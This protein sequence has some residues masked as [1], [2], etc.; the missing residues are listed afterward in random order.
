MLPLPALSRAAVLLQSGS[1]LT[2]GLAAAAA[3]YAGSV[4]GLQLRIPPATPSV[5]WPPN[6]I[7]TVLLLFVPPARW[8][9]VLGGAAIAHFAV[10]LQV[11]S[12]AFVATIFL[13]NCTEAALAAGGVRYFSQDATRFD[14]LRSVSIF[15]A[16]GA[17]VAPF[18][19]TFLDAAVVERFNREDYWHVWTVRFPS[20]VVAQLAIVPALS[21]ILNGGAGVFRGPKRKWLEATAI[22]GGLILM[23]IAV[24]FD[25]GRIGLSWT[26]LAPFLPFLL[27]SAV[28]FGSTGVG[29]SVLGTVLLS[30][31]GALYGD[32]IHPMLEP[33][34]RIRTLQIFLISAAVPLLCVGALVE[35]RQ[36]AAKA[37]RSSDLLK[38]SILTSIPSLVA[39]IGRNGR[40]VA[41]NE[42]WR[43]AREQ[44]L[45]S[46]F[47]GEPGSSYLDVWAAA[48]ARQL[49]SAR[50]GFDGIRSVLDG[51]AP[52]FALEYR[53]VG[54]Q[55]HWWMMSVV[56]LKSDE[57]GAVITHTD[58]TARKRD[59]MVAQE[60][61]DE[62]AHTTRVFVMG[63]LTASLSHQL[64][65]PLTGIMGNAHAARRF[66]DAQPPNMAE[67]RQILEDIVADTQRAAD[68][69]AT[70]RDMIRKD[71]WLDELVDVNDIVRDTTTLVT[72]QALIR[73]VGMHLQLAPSLPVVRG[74]RVQLCQVVLNLTLNAIESI[75]DANVREAK[76]VTVRTE[77]LDS[78]AVQVS[79]VDCGCGLP[80]GAEDQVFEPLYT[81]KQSGMGMGL[82]I[83]RA[84]VE[85]HGGTMSADNWPSGGAIF[86]FTLPAS[87][88]ERV[89]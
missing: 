53:T 39:V 64:S 61:R 27:W 85:A 45:M 40:I 56:P 30:V 10:G 6:A 87:V 83:A 24:A 49:P 52:G 21:G 58:I 79:V 2:I 48:A 59:E 82:S 65:Q 43:A 31:G 14:T 13:T 50:A 35:E 55:E 5:L 68:V 19:S 47:S 23:A 34:A 74:K 77:R 18:A 67:V 75:A 20:N 25:S 16:M 22:A 54:K 7:L 89:S 11:W 86:R 72:S 29:L 33:E 63:E 12:P 80:A 88:E 46:E 81:T 71:V 51:S 8:W 84:I 73:D 62:L 3:Y 1:P 41:V 38:S 76:A 70:I 78:T 4:L 15:L 69:T 60:S 42:S 37:L 66:L 44:G 57:G 28:R 9:S 32:G 36:N 26:P 17:F